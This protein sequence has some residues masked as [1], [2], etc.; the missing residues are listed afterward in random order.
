MFQPVIINENDIIE[1]NCMCRLSEDTLRRRHRTRL[2]SEVCYRK[3][4]I[5]NCIFNNPKSKQSSIHPYYHNSDFD[6]NIDK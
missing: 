3:S 1:C 4:N 6:Q 2:Q 5:V